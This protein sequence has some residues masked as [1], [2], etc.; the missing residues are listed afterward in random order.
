MIFYFFQPYHGYPY[1]T[2]DNPMKLPKIIL[3]CFVSILTTGSLWFV[4]KM[5]LMLISVLPNH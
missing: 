3:I 2:E 1:Q 4:T 5:F